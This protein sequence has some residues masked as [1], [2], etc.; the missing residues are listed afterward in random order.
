MIVSDDRVAV[1]VAE[2]M[3]VL[4]YP[5]FRSLGIERGGQI[6]AGVVFNVF[7]AADVHV[8]V[9]GAGWTKAFLAECGHYAF[10]MLGKRRVTVITEQPRVVRL[11]EKLGG[12][13]EGCLREHF[14][15]GRDAFIVGILASEYR[16]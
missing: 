2:S 12:S 13:I 7:E 10:S 16:Y 4:F 8:S 3:G 15:E 11:A 6:V 5:P 9:A 1:F 14:G